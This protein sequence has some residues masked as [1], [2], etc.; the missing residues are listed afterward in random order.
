MKLKHCEPYA[1]L[2]K[3]SFMG[4]SDQLDAIFK[5]AQE[6]RKQGL[7]LPPETVQWIDHC[8]LVKAKFKKN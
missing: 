1:P 7:T 8:E 4:V 5:M 6:L 2:R 3:E